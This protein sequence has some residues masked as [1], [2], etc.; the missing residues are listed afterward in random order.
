LCEQEAEY[1]E[2]I[3]YSRKLVEV[4]PLNEEAHCALMRLYAGS[5][6]REAALRQYSLCEKYLLEELGLEPEEATTEL[7]TKIRGNRPVRVQSPEAMHHGAPRL[8]VLP[9]KNLS[10]Q[11]EWFSDGMTDALITELSRREELEVISYTSSMLYRDTK[12]SPRQVAAELDV[13]HLLEG[14]VLKA[15]KEV[16]ITAQLIEAASDRHVWAESYRG[17]FANILE[18]QDKIAYSVVA[19]VVDKLA[20]GG[21]K[22]TVLEID[23]ETREACMMGDHLLRR[24]RGEEEIDRA[25]D[26]YLRAI[27]RDQHCADAYAGLAFTYFSLGGYGRDVSPSKENRDRV[28]TYI[29]QSLQIDPN[30]VRAHM[31]LG[32]LHLEW[33]WDWAS[34]EREFQEVLRIDPNHID[35]LN[36]YSFLKMAFC[37]FDEQFTLVQ[38]AYR[39]DPLNLVT[40]VHL[41]RYYCATFQYRRS[42]QTLDRIEELYPGQH[43]IFTYRAWVYLLKG[44]YQT[45]ITRGEALSDPF[46]YDMFRG[47]LVYAYGKAGQKDRALQMIADMQEKYRKNDGSIDASSIALA[48]HGVGQDE[49]ALEWLEQAYKDRDVYLVQLAHRTPWGELHWD[50]RFQDLLRRIGV[51]IQLEYIRKALDRIPAHGTAP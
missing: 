1:T 14:A 3:I 33:E 27:D 40:L 41:H 13:D 37:R 8:V 43:S 5:G 16:R 25:K 50:S 20:A 30:N 2:G 19:R 36:W 26:Y 48:Y 35:T 21:S 49:E 34:A 51:P 11:Q 12:K 29:Q 6:Q 10:E 32:G 44:Q 9:F 7:Y 22:T 24:S 23:P 39:L 4:D 47:R 28:L 18:L 46:V 15:G 45:V 38:K 31:V 17:S 42:L